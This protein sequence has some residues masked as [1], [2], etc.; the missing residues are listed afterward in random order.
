MRPRTTR[1]GRWRRQI[2]DACKLNFELAR[3][4]ESVTAI[5]KKLTGLAFALT[6][7]CIAVGFLLAA[8]R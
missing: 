7:L 2:S 3:F 5:V 1:L 8:L 4:V 6:G